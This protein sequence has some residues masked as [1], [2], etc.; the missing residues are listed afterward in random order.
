MRGV[1]KKGVL[2]DFAV[3]DY[4]LVARV[5]QPGITP[6]LINTW[7]G[8]WRVVSKTEGHVYRVKDIAT[9]SLREV[10]IA[11][12]QPYADAS[13]NVTAELKEVFNNLKSQGEF[14]MEM[15]DA[16]DLAADN[17][18]YVIKVKWVGLDEVETTWEPLSTIHTD[19]PK[20]V[21]L[22][23]LRLTKEVRDDLKK[24]MALKFDF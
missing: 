18:E 7:T 4:V 14:D 19:A 21:Q 20:Y 16:V 12:M 15:I 23:K 9:G 10:Y 2:P 11:Q 24:S 13:L 3:E 8:P 17:E 6:K 22:R 1:K 5:R